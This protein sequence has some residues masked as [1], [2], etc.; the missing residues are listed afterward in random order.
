MDDALKKLQKDLDIAEQM[1]NSM[2]DYLRM[3]TL[4][5]KMPPSMPALTL[6]GYLMRQH[7]LLELHKALPEVD[8]QRLATLVERFNNLVA[9]RIVQTEEKAH[10]ELGARLR[11]WEETIRDLRRD[12]RGNASFYHTAVEAR[13]M[14]SALLEM[15]DDPPFELR[16]DISE[17]LET[18]DS[19][20]KALWQTGN[21]IWPEEWEP[22]YPQSDYW[23]LYGEP[24][25]VNKS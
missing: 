11:Q 5:G 25:I 15:L 23:Y 8:R 17:R 19:G 12:L 7:R 18:L 20:L 21:L 6:G 1:V 22:A 10:K 14:I 4:F 2:E 9:T 16:D 3:D 24:R 13:A